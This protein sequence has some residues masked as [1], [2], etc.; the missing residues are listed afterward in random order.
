MKFEV[1]QLYRF[2]APVEVI[3][4]FEGDD[5][6]RPRAL[7]YGT[8]ISSDNLSCTFKGVVD[9]KQCRF[10]LAKDRIWENGEPTPIDD[11]DRPMRYPFY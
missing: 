11:E 6:S 5:G 10:Q 2:P 8:F 4:F 3:C 7:D 1:D 9:G